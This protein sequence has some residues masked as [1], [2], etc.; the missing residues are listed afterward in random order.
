MMALNHISVKYE[1][2]K[3]IDVCDSHVIIMDFP[4]MPTITIAFIPTLR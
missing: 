3:R 2:F 1:S 4:Q